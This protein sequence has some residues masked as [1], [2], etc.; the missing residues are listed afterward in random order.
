MHLRRPVQFTATQTHDLPAWMDHLEYS[1]IIFESC[2]FSYV[3]MNSHFHRIDASHTYATHWYTAGCWWD[4][5]G[6]VS[7][8][9][10]PIVG[11]SFFQA[12]NVPQHFPAI[13]S[14]EC[15]GSTPIMTGH[16]LW[17]DCPSSGA[18]VHLSHFRP[19]INLSEWAE[20]G[21]IEWI[22]VLLTLRMK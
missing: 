22:N 2:L 17:G 14:K 7:L 10:S 9:F 18:Q 16:W 3:G 12:W 8:E 13:Y 11:V 20:Y 1:T 4:G 21:W 19:G 5:S 15:I 6:N